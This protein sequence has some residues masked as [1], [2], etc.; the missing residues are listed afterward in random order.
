MAE[1]FITYKGFPLVRNGNQIYYGNMSDEF[2][3]NITVVST[4]NVDGMDIA[5]KL[6][7][8]LLRTAKDIDPKDMVVKTSDRSSLYEALDVANIWLTR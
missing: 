2:V 7:V 3:A 6:K 4:K 1:E 8:V 5:D